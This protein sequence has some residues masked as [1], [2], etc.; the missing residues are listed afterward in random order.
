MRSDRPDG[1]TGASTLQVSRVRLEAVL[2]A[3]DAMSVLARKTP[4]RLLNV[5]TSGCLVECGE[6]LEPGTTGALKVVG[7]DG[8]ACDDAVR[9]TRALQLKGAGVWHVGIEFLWTS[10]P[11]RWSL[12]RMAGRFR[13]EMAHS[14]VV[15]AMTRVGPH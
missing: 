6:Y 4:V 15:A 2:S 14:E 8:K 11:G 5:G 3:A 12:R 10:H 9:V 1:R 13:Q 7:G